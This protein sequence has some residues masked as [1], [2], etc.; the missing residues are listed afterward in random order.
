M[1]YFKDMKFAYRTTLTL[2]IVFISMTLLMVASSLVYPEKRRI[3]DL[4][5]GVV[6]LGVC[7]AL[8]LASALKLKKEMKQQ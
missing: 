5:T 2:G 1:K 7:S 6:F 3:G 4:I 8:L